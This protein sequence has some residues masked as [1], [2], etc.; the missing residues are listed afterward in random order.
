MVLNAD[1]ATQYWSKTLLDQVVC[2]PVIGD[3]LLYVAGLDQYLWAYDL[4][5]GRT[6]WSVLTDAPL[7]SSPTLIGD[8]LYQ[9]I[10]GTGLSCFNAAPMDRPGGE[11]HWVSSRVTGNVVHERRGDLFAWDM[12]NKRLQIVEANRGGLKKTIDLP[13]VD[14]FLVGGPSNNEIFAA[15]KDGRVVHLSPRN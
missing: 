12:Q 4:A 15:S 14:Y 5:G 13:Q 11:Q 6:Q 1:S 3:G 7:T 9:Q 8:R 2:K 10:P